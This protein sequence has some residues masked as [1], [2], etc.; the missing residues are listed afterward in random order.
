MAAAER[1]QRVTIAWSELRRQLASNRTRRA[2]LVPLVGYVGILIAVQLLASNGYRSTGLVVALLLVVVLLATGLWIVSGITDTEN[3]SE[4]T[5]ATPAMN[6]VAVL[7][8]PPISLIIALGVNWETS[9]IGVS[10]FA[11]I[12]ILLISAILIVRLLNMS[13]GGLG[14]SLPRSTASWL[15]TGVAGG[16]GAVLGWILFSLLDPAPL[17]A[18]SDRRMIAFLCLLFLL[19]GAVEEF[20]YRG[21][22]RVALDRGF[23]IVI[24]AL[25]GATIFAAMTTGFRSIAAV[26][27]IWATALLA[28]VVVRKT[29]S[30]AGASL[31]RGVSLV[32]LFVLLP[33]NDAGLIW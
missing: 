27:I 17:I 28:D 10:H 4:P 25:L 19:G 6:V 18:T 16:L 3:V 15:I 30:L 5:F 12:P 1:R 13:T 23:E 22:M 9:R 11:D 24:S 20:I 21:V 32:F 2:P 14:L 8:V 33:L 7:L 31:A 29:G 26:M